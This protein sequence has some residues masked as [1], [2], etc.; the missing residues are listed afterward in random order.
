MDDDDDDGA[1][2]PVV[3]VD[4][5]IFAM[6]DPVRL[7]D[8]YLNCYQYISYYCL[9]EIREYN[10]RLHAVCLDNQ[11]IHKFVINRNNQIE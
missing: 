7:C 6:I 3:V 1:Y 9:N 10:C 8:K 2:Y 11:E 5:L 4:A